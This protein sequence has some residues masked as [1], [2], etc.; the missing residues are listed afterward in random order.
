VGHQVI[1]RGQKEF[2]G[3][4]RRQLDTSSRN[5]SNLFFAPCYHKVFHTMGSLLASPKFKSEGKDKRVRRGKC[6]DK[7]EG[8]A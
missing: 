1:P 5:S 7:G 8:N 6:K 3:V 2:G 4:A